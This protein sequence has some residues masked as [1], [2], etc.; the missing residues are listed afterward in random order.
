MCRCVLDV[1]LSLWASHAHYDF[2]GS[3]SPNTASLQI[4]LF[5][6][7]FGFSNI[8]IMMIVARL[9]SILI[10]Y[11]LIENIDLYF[12]SNLRCAYAGCVM[13]D[14][15]TKMNFKSIGLF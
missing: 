1:S 11:L 2:S 6:R 12:I 5:A 3:K 8:L 7:K 4:R 15:V 9:E 14:R 10:S 13:E